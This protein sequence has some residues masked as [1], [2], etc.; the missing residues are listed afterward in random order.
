MGSSSRMF[1]L[2]LIH[3]CRAAPEADLVTSLPGAAS[4]PAP[5]YS[6]FLN[7]G[8]GVRLHYW[9]ATCSTDADWASKPT[10]LWLNGG[11]GSSSVIGMLQEAGPLLIGKDGG[12]HE[13]PWA[14]SKR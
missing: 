12:L 2:L 11:P 6:G 9:M 3:S 13:N 4:L 7:G 8:D 10:V 5:M 1:G 14:W